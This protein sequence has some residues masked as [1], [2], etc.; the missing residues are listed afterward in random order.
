[1][2]LTMEVWTIFLATVG[3]DLANL[4]LLIAEMTN[5][6]KIA[7]KVKSVM[8]VEAVEIWLIQLIVKLVSGMDL[9]LLSPS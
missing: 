3:L 8:G 2:A 5:S 4:W 1:M 6:I 9:S 7:L